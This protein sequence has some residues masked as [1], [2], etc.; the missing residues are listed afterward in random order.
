MCSLFVICLTTQQICSGAKKYARR[1][2]LYCA[3]LSDEPIGEFITLCALTPN[4]VEWMEP[5]ISLNKMVQAITSTQF[6][7]LFAHPRFGHVY[8]LTHWMYTKTL[9]FSSGV[10]H[11]CCAHD[12]SNT[13]T[14]W[15]EPS[16]GVCYKLV[17]SPTWLQP[18]ENLWKCIWV[19]IKIKCLYVTCN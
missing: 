2:S 12:F 1:Q 19:F 8:A 6:S 5:M 17:K 18:H 3:K 14:Y 15:D 10:L 13:F 7:S 11:W 16:I 4:Q 9:I